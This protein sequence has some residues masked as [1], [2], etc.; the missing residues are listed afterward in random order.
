MRIYVASS[1]RNKLQPE[2]VAVLQRYDHDV[3][4]FRN[5]SPEDTGFRWTD[6]G[7]DWEMTEGPDG[8]PMVNSVNF[9]KLLQSARAVDG[10]MHDIRALRECERVRARSPIRPERELG[11]RLR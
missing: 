4:N 6:C 9:T 3:Y 8:R 10:Y 7:G 2:V 5:P 11:V 1:W